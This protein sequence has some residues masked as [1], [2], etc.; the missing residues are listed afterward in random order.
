MPIGEFAIADI[1]IVVV[2]LV[3]AV[4]G[5]LR[6]F[7]REVVSLVIWVAA[8]LLGVLCG[9]RLG[10]LIADSLGPRLQVAV[11]FAVIFIVVL[12]LGALVQRLLGRLVESTGLTGTDRTLGLLFGTV[13]GGA[14]VVIALIVVR[15]FVEDRPWWPESQLIPPLMA[16]EADVLDLVNYGA[17]TLGETVVGEEPVSTE[18]AI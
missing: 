12:V 9:A 16:L 13:R 7:V 2:V 15:P 14:V 3:S 11:G 8:S 18:E 4:F 5:V 1:V 17:D 10:T 6:G